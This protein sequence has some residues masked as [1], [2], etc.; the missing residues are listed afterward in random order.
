MIVFSSSQ[1]NTVFEWFLSCRKHPSPSLWCQ[2]A[3]KR[4]KSSFNGVLRR[5][6]RSIQSIA[7]CE[8]TRGALGWGTSHMPYTG[9]VT[10][11]HTH[12]HT[13]L[14]TY[15]HSLSL[16]LS[17][18]QKVLFRFCYSKP[19]NSVSWETNS[20]KDVCWNEVF[21]IEKLK[22]NFFFTLKWLLLLCW[23]ILISTNI[24]FFLF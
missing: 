6:Q 10:H 16:S 24:H 21:R 3:F 8:K 14:H 2:I 22:F 4:P 9:W 7:L 17:H 23:R 5:E 12:L 11:T 1:K 15:T 13:H 20:W 18:L 19:D